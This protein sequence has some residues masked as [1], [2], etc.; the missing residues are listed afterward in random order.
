MIDQNTVHTVLSSFLFEPNTKALRAKMVKVLEGL[1]P[2]IM[3]E[4]MTTDFM[5]KHGA[6]RFHVSTGFKLYKVEYGPGYKRFLV[7]EVNKF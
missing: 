1:G 2:G 3:A 7:E 5:I 6:V 4:D